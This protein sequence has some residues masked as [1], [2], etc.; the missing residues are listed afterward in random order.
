MTRVASSYSRNASEWRALLNFESDP[1]KRSLNA[2]LTGSSMP[3]FGTYEEPPDSLV[4]RI[5]GLKEKPTTQDEIKRAFRKRVRETHPDLQG[6]NPMD[7]S[8]AVGWGRAQQTAEFQEVVWAR[9]VLLRKVREAPRATNGKRVTF[10]EP[11]DIPQSA[12]YNTAD[13]LEAEYRKWRTEADPKVWGSVPTTEE[14]WIPGVKRHLKAEAV[15]TAELCGVCARDIGPDEPVEWRSWRELRCS[16]CS[17]GLKAGTNP[18]KNCQRP[19][20]DRRRGSSHTLCCERCKTAFYN[21]RARE[22]RA[23]REAR[24]RSWN[25][26]KCVGCG[27]VIENRRADARY[28]NDACRQKAYRQRKR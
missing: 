19:T 20:W 17:L 3:R 24:R 1:T 8:I 18:C 7:W 27:K 14:E 4:L 11:P 16:Y 25:P 13:R 6:H 28:H 9:D 12:T 10:S 26:P 15:K 21:R 2:L 22:R 23:R 5:L